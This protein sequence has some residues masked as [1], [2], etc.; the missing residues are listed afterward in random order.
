MTETEGEK[1]KT[2]KENRIYFTYPVTDGED[3][4]PVYTLLFIFELC[5][6]H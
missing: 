2:E 5:Q 6:Y 4:L 3:S 1:K